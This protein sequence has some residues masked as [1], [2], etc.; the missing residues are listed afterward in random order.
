MTAE[1]HSGGD[2]PQ[3]T[4]APEAASG[5]TR[6]IPA[7]PI[8][9]WVVIVLVAGL[10]IGV[11]AVRDRPGLGTGK[12]GSRLFE[13]Q[14]KYVVGT[15]SLLGDQGR[16]MAL[17]QLDQLPAPGPFGQLRIAVLAGEL[18]DAENALERL[19]ETSANN[20]EAD[21]NSNEVATLKSDLIELYEARAG[22]DSAEETLTDRQRQR[23]RSELGWFGRLALAPPNRSEAV[24]AE[25]MA[26]ARRVVW[27]TV[28][29]FV[30]FAAVALSGLAV[31][32][33]FLHH[34]ITDRRLAM[35]AVPAC[36]NVYAET[37]AIWIS[38]FLLFNFVLGYTF[39][40]RAIV[41]VGLGA[42]IGSALALGW[43]LWRGVPWLQ[44]CRDLGWSRGRGILRETVA[45]V[46]AYAM[47]L[48][49]AAGAVLL[50]SFLFSFFLGDQDLTDAPNHPLAGWLAEAS[51]WRVVSLVI[52]ACV[53]APLVEETVFRGLLYRHLREALASRR[54]W[55]SVASSTLI[56]SVVFG[57]LH[58]QGLPL[59]PG[60]IG[61]AVA[62]SFMRE[63][64]DTLIPSVIGHAI[65][66][67]VT[68][69]VLLTVLKLA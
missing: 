4:S 52:L 67:T 59:I 46:G 17:S 27:I 57:S 64:R 6:K 62:L 31:L 42:F 3:R 22:S 34:L 19:G 47:A 53:A 56:S 69:G 16:S 1:Q 9:A 26:E 24:R 41:R 20:G 37:F 21:G 55:I 5:G 23:L 40:P 61:I 38:L 45:G 8:V 39:G 66:N 25:V 13:F 10:I 65:N 11:S 58:P 15:A 18:G 32:A 54:R 29:G 7:R 60:V 44:L 51:G 35:E 28:T 36:G 2:T 48:P 12:L 63:W 49:I 33:V 30:V 43:P 50:S 68:V 14:A